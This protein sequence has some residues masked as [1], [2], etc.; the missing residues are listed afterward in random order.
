[1]K[2]KAVLVIGFIGLIWLSSP[3][4]AEEARLLPLTGFQKKSKHK[5]NI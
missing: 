3:G 1:M 4:L 5:D 2:R